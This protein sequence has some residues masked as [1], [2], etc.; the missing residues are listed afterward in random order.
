MTTLIR[1]KTKL[2]CTAVNVVYKSKNGSYRGFV[3][4]Y[5]ITYEDDTSEKVLSALK[6]MTIEYEEGL[7][8]YNNPSHLSVVPLSDEEDKEK[9]NNISPS[10]VQQLITKRFKVVSPDYYA[11]ARLCA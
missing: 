9:W 4:P 10:L 5:D 7:K 6:D 8:K 1:E 11:E 3:Q 2:D